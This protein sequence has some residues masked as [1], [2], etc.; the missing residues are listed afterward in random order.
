YPRLFISAMVMDVLGIIHNIFITGLPVQDQ[1]VQFVLLI[2]LTVM[3]VTRNKNSVAHHVM[4]L[5]LLIM[6]IVGLALDEV[7]LLNV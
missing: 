5:A 4:A 2:A 3:V 6:A 7:S 1:I